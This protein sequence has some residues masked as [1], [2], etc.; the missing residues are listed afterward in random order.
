MSMVHSG[1]RTYDEGVAS[2][3][4]RLQSALSTATTQAQHNTANAAHFRRCLALAKSNGGPVAFWIAALAEI[5][6]TP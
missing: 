6:A 1:N 4:E 5:G 3:V 2:S